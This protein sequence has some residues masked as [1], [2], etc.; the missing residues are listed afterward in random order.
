MNLYQV[1]RF[2]KELKSRIFNK[3]NFT[4]WPALVVAILIIAFFPSAYW[5]NFAANEQG[6]WPRVGQSD[7]NWSEVKSLDSLK[8]SSS[9]ALVVGLPTGQILASQKPHSY[10]PLASLT[11][12]FSIGLLD[13][14]GLAW[15]GELSID[16]KDKKDS[17][18]GL[19][20]DNDVASQLPV[21]K[22]E[23][24]S[25]SDLV[26]ASL[27]ISANNAVLALIK[28]TSVGLVE[29]INEMNQMAKSQHFSSLS[30]YEPT[31]LNV[32]NQGT[33]LDVA[34]MAIWA[35][36]SPRVKNICG[37]EATNITSE[38]GTIYRL[39]NTNDLFTINKNF[40]ILASKTGHLEEA[41][42]NLV[43]EVESS[44]GKRYILVLL[45]S[46]SKVSRQTDVDKIMSWLENN[47][48]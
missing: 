23:I 3:K 42:Y 21:H 26:K 27:I 46:K 10:W 20:D 31:G 12:L 36:Q 22:T 13:R 1:M 34:R 17:E 4:A 48:L 16:T 47:S 9:S 24:F 15:Q 44:N 2:W 33:A 14:T 35:W 19:L 28:N 29:F 43:M 11:K 30:F 8:L 37:T 39:D 41:G 7:I 25:G 32:K 38:S 5:R 6:L 45:G 18:R 40:K